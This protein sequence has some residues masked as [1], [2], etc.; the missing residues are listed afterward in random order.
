MM[1]EANFDEVVV[2]EPN[3]TSHCYTIVQLGVTD[4]NARRLLAMVINLKKQ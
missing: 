1:T 4:R 2:G 3:S